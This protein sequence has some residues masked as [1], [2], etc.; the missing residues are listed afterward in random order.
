VMEQLNEEN[1]MSMKKAFNP[2]WAIGIALLI[3]LIV[4]YLIYRKKVEKA[5]NEE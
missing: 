3:I 4:F 2:L 5:Q 1:N